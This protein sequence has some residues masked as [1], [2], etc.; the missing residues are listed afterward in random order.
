VLAAY[1]TFEMERF[2][3][4]PNFAYIEAKLKEN[5]V[6][7]DARAIRKAQDEIDHIHSEL[8]AIPYEPFNDGAWSRLPLWAQ[9]KLTR[10]VH[11]QVISAIANENEK[12]ADERIHLEALNDLGEV[13]LLEL[14]A[15]DR[16]PEVRLAFEKGVLNIERHSLLR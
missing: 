2:K 11:K 5:K 4:S 12:P 13:V 16:M 8:A 6:R 10:S 3:N 7:Q 9:F 14:E 1:E 15:A